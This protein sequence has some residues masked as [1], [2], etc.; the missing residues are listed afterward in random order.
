[1][2]LSVA[3]QHTV[4]KLLFCKIEPFNTTCMCLHFFS[5]TYWH[6]YVDSRLC[7]AHVLLILWWCCNLL[8]FVFFGSA[9][10]ICSSD[11]RFRVFSKTNIVMSLF[12]SVI[13]WSYSWWTMAMYHPYSWRY[14]AI[15]KIMVWKP[16][17]N[18]YHI[19]LSMHIYAYGYHIK[20][21]SWSSEVC[22]G[23]G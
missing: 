5:R 4:R 2:W 23:M 12:I 13:F 7:F 15:S 9:S 3:F 16:G 17:T 14:P 18:I 22:C 8:F 19:C 11:D 21:C 20:P 10:L 1:M 6:L